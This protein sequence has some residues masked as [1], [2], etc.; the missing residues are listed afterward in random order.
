ML[1]IFLRAILVQMVS[2]AGT[3]YSFN[4]RRPRLRDKLVMRIRFLKEFAGT[5]F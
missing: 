1:S 4:V 2:G 3:G 5:P